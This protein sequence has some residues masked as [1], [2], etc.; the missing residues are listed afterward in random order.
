MQHESSKCLFYDTFMKSKILLFCLLFAVQWADAQSYER[1][2]GQV[3]LFCGAD[4]GYADTNWLRL[5]DVQVNATPG[6]RWHLGHD[7]TLAAQGLIPVVSDGYTFR[8]RIHKY[9]RANM[10]TVSRQLHFNEAKQHLKLTA[11]WFGEQRYGLDVRWMW[12]VNSWLLLQAQSGFSAHWLLG[13]DLKGNYEADLDSHFSLTGVAGANVYLQPWNIE[14]RLSGGKYI[15]NDYGIQ[16]DVMRHFSH[17]T[18]LAFAQFRIGELMIGQFEKQEYRT[19]G[20]FK[21]IMMLPPYKKSTRKLVVRPASNFRLTN[22]MRSG[23]Q[24]MRMYT[25]DPEENER[26]LQLDVNWGL[27]GEK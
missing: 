2:V 17:C 21:V 10:A 14:F 4:F 20:G 1:P 11:G 5:Y 23:G 27:R 15:A 3:E 8:D 6:F 19:N 12:L 25:T 13:A 9:W 26:E 22:S 24:S 16:F 18:L 7:W